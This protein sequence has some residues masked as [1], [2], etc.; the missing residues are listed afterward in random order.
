[1]SGTFFDG[2]AHLLRSALSAAGIYLVIV[3]A[4]RVF[5]EKALAKMSGY[6][7]IV[8]VAL[9]SVVATLPL[10]TSVSIVDAIAAAITF[11]GLQ[12]VMRYLQARHRRAHTLV[13]ERPRLLLW[14]GRLLEDRMLESDI[15]ADEV[16]AAVRRSGILSLKQ[17]RAAILE[18]DGEW[19]IIPQTSAPDL[20]AM[21]GLL[22]P[23]DNEPPAAEP[24]Q[25]KTHVA[26]QSTF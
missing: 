23:K 3:A 20:S 14:N 7:M 2:W 26:R 15:S 6:D 8:T 22:I 10:T 4:I 12:Q 21:E 1:M 9:G 25:K 17:V 5:G 18:N 13:R 24:V 16:R 11:L 19:S